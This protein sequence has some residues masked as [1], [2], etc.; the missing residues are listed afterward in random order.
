[1][2]PVRYKLDHY[3]LFRLCYP[4]SSRN[5]W[6]GSP[7]SKLLLRA[8]SAPDLNSYK[9]RPSAVKATKLS[10]NIIY[11]SKSR[12]PC[13]KPLLITVLTTS[14]SHFPYQKDERAK[15]GNLLRKSPL[16]P[17]HSPTKESLISFITFI[18]TYSCTILSYLS[19]GRGFKS[20]RALIWLLLDKTEKH[21]AH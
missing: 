8:W 1:M 21:F 3:I 15:P 10:L 7:S 13:L 11:K 6:V 4:M 17:T 14:R 9:L 18:F 19:C 12:G 20:F 2:F 16:S 5:C